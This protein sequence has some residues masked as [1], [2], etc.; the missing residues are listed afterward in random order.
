MI[1]W[2]AAHNGLSPL[3]AASAS[4]GPTDLIKSDTILL[5]AVE[6]DTEMDQP[7]HLCAELFGIKAVALRALI[8]KA[9][10]ASQ[11][12][13]RAHVSNLE[14]SKG[15]FAFNYSEAIRRARWPPSTCWYRKIDHRLA[16]CLTP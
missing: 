11:Q 2:Q 14:V 4:C 15:C 9:A 6:N 8:K 7:R 13:R 10:A 16:N 5:R 12:Q 3:I 1:G